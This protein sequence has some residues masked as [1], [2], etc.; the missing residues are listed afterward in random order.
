[1]PDLLPLISLCIAARRLQVQYAFPVIASK[2]MMAAAYP[3]VKAQAAQQNTQIVEPDLES[4]LPLKI[5]RINRERLLTF[6]PHWRGR[7][8][9]SFQTE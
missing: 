6:F 5:C 1:L 8:F 2:D 3:L 4:A 7:S 9:G